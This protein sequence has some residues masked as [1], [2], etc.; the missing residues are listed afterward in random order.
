MNLLYRCFAI[1]DGDNLN[2]FS[3]ESQIHNLLD[4]DAVIR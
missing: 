3:R 2:A 1:T 4:G